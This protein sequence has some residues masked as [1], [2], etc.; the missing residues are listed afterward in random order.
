MFIMVDLLTN[1]LQPLQAFIARS[2]HKLP[3]DLNMNI[4]FVYAAAVGA[5]GHSRKYYC[6]ASCAFALVSFVSAA[7][8]ITHRTRTMLVP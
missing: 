1:L 7:G 3:I 8:T 5:G 4:S 2:L 6:A